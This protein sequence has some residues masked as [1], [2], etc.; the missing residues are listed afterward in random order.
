MTPIPSLISL[1]IGGTVGTAEGKGITGT[2]AAASPLPGREVRRIVRETL[3]IVPRISDSL[4]AEV[5][6]AL[7]IRRSDFPADYV[8]PHLRLYPDSLAAIE[9]LSRLAP[10]VTLSNVCSLDFDAVAMGSILGTYITGQH[11]SCDLGYAKPDRAAFQ[12]VA[13]RYGVPI[14]SL[15][16]IGD[17][18]ECDVLGALSAGARAMWISRD[19]AVPPSAAFRADRLTVISDLAAAARELHTCMK[20]SI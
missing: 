13:D 20:G 11:A 4:F 17:D 12:M 10:V 1:D 16:H 3:H 14:G 19:R 7:R 2:L 18:W 9:S 8:P 6:K 5:C 15:L